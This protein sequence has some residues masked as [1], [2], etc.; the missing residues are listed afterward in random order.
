MTEG[1]ATPKVVI[2]T[3]AVMPGTYGIATNA[4]P[5]MATQSPARRPRASR[6]ET[7]R[8][9]RRCEYQPATTIA[10]TLPLDGNAPRTP[11]APCV[12]PSPLMRNAPCQDSACDSAQFAPN[13]AD[14]HARIVGLNSSR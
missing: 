13:A 9:S 7:P 8:D 5:P 10:T 6:L 2:N 12:R 3:F 14:Q 4:A 11:I 1:S